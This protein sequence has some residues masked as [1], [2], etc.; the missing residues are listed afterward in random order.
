MNAEM[1]RD[2]NAFLGVIGVIERHIFPPNQ[3]N[4]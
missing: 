1:L 2:E 4:R 3:E